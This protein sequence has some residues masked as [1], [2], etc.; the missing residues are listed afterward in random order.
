MTLTSPRVPRL[1]RWLRSSGELPL[2]RIRSRVSAYLYGN[3][4]VL[5]AVIGASDETEAHW[6]ALLVVGAT[7]VT[8]FLA[9]VVAHGVG[10]QIGRTDEDARL[11]VGAELRDAVPIITSGL[12]P[13]VVMALGALG[14]L[15]PLWV[16][17]IAGG[18]LVVR[19]ALSGIQVERLSDDRSSAGVLWAGFGLAAV[20]LV[21][22]A[23]K[24]LFT[25]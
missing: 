3:I 10:Q 5:A 19:I 16:E 8:T 7:T 1:P 23:L 17:V 6:S 24:V 25:H 2:P 21:I 12:V 9:H 22:V 15:S 4:L 20:S 14:V 13:L 18:I 11:H